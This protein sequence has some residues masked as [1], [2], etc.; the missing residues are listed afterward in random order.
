MREFAMVAVWAL[1]AI[2]IS[3]RADNQSI[4]I[5]ALV[6]AGLITL[7]TSIHAYQNRKNLYLRFIKQQPVDEK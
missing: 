2:A 3:N 4:F 6:A 7:N 5:T 1:I